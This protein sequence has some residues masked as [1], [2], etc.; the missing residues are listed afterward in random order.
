MIDDRRKGDIMMSAEERVRILE[1]AKPNSWLAL[2]SDESKVVG[3]GDTYAEAVA[4]AE[5]HGEEDPILISI[6]DNWNS[7]VFRLCA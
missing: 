1:A 2:A 7:R 6:P 3:R 5:K 4:D